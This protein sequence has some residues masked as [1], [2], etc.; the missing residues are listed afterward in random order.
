MTE[1]AGRWKHIAPDRGKLIFARIFIA[2]EY[3]SFVA[4]EEDATSQL[5]G[6]L[7]PRRLIVGLEQRLTASVDED[8]DIL[9]KVTDY[10]VVP[11]HFDDVFEKIEALDTTVME[12]DKLIS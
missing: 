9:I 3:S 6:I 10:T 1:E 5:D 4:R 12:E 8:S 2:R 11:R 7:S